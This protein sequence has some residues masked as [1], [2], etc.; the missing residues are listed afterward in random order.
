MQQEAEVRTV[1][2]VRKK[3]RCGI[4]EKGDRHA[5]EVHREPHG[6]PILLNSPLDERALMVN[7]V[8]L[9]GACSVVV[10]RNPYTASKNKISLSLCGK[11][12]AMNLDCDG[13]Q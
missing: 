11:Y 2:S 13:T 7:I 6:E 9:H 8:T 1:T 10:T 12:L 3:R 4:L 5:R